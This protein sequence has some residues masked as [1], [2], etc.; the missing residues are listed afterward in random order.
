[1][2]PVSAG[3]SNGEN[4][5]SGG[6]SS[7]CE[8]MASQIQ[9]R[10]VNSSLTRLPACVYMNQ[11]GHQFQVNAMQC[12]QISNLEVEV[13]K[14]LC[15]IDDGS[16]NGL[17]GVGMRLYEMAEH[18]EHVDIV[19]ASDDIQD[20]MKSLPIGTYCAVVTSATSKHCLG[21]FYN[22]V[23]Y[24]KGKSILSVKQSLAFGIK[25]YPEPRC[26]GGKQKI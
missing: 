19:G 5:Q 4:N 15:L 8:I 23:S 7:I 9:P 16:N 26:Y 21:L 2:T 10:E 12:L 25:S 6:T 3:I 1:M 17:V 13:N 22:Y 20:G 24:C 18:P 11:T 14:E